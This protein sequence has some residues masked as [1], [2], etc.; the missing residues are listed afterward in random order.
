MPDWDFN[1]PIQDT[2]ALCE[3]L[4]ETMREFQ[5]IGLAANQ[6]GVETRAFSMETD[7]GP[8]VLFNPTLIFIGDD[9]HLMREGCLSFPG[10]E[11]Y[12]ERSVEVAVSY[13]EPTGKSVVKSF[14]GITARCA[15]HEI[16]HLDGIV[17]TSRVSKLKL[18]MAKKKM[19]KSENKT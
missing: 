1:N 16:D 3:S 13:Q 15:L 4:V 5:G 14:H 18:A 6:V 8:I 12:L 10:L 9:Q 7:E 17:F 11:L 2:D 19:K